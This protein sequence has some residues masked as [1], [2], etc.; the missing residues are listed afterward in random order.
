MWCFATAGNV[1]G[2]QDLTISAGSGAVN[3]SAMGAST[4]IGALDIDST[5]T[6]TVNG[7]IVA[8]SIALDGAA[9]VDLATGAITLT[10]VQRMEQLI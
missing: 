2:A 7:N 6:T 8:G 10:Q 4:A 3:L 5:G 1:D 9:D